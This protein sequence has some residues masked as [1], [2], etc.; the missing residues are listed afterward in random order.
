MELN[1]AYYLMIDGTTKGEF[2]YYFKDDILLG[3]FN[4]YDFKN[5]N[6]VF[7][8]I[9][10]G[11]KWINPDKDGFI[12]ISGLIPKIVKDKNYRKNYVTKSD[13]KKYLKGGTNE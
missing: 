10:N 11:L 7:S 9:S 12:K 1:G 5:K 3:S 4:I 8:K 6:I 2:V 13:F